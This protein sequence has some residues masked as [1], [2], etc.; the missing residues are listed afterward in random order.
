V[1]V[2]R[3]VTIVRWENLHRRQLLFAVVCENAPNGTSPR[4]SILVLSSWQNQS[5]PGVLQGAYRG[6]VENPE[7]SCQIKHVSIPMPG[8]MFGAFSHHICLM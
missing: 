6:P 5:W 8:S 7:K 2:Q 3:R 1:K 4:S